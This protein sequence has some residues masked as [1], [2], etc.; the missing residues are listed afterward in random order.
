MIR[1]NGW[2]WNNGKAGWTQCATGHRT[3]K[4]WLWERPGG[5][6]YCKA[7]AIRLFSQTVPSL[8]DCGGWI[9]SRHPLNLAHSTTP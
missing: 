7:C 3:G 1:V 5:G 6:D 9:H 8:I 2:W 4:G